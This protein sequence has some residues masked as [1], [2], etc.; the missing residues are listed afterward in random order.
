MPK[1]LNSKL[2]R[3]GEEIRQGRAKSA[4]EE[5]QKLCSRGVD[6]KYAAPIASLARRAA[7]ADLGLRALHKIVRPTGRLPIPA[8]DE[9]KLEYAACL[10]KIGAT[11]ESLDILESLDAAK[12]PDVLLFKTF[13]LVSQWEYAATIP[14]L[15][16]YLR[17]PDIT[18]YWRMVAKVN[19]A[20]AFVYER[21]SDEAD[22]CLAEI[23]A[24]TKGTE[25][26]LLHGNA[27]HLSLANAVLRRDFAK[28]AAC[29]KECRALLGNT[30]LETFFLRKWEAIAAMLQEGS[31]E[32]MDAVRAEATKRSHWETLRDCDRYSLL[33]TRDAA[34][35][36]KLIFG[37]PYAGFRKSLNLGDI[38]VPAS[39]VWGLG[40]TAHVVK[41]KEFEPGTALNRLLHALATDFY[42]PFR[43]AALYAR[44][45]PG[46]F[47][48]PVSA[49]GKMHQ[50]MKRF[51]DLCAK[52]K[53]KL[54]VSEAGGFY[55]LTAAEGW[56]VEVEL[57]A[58]PKER[59]ESGLDVLRGRCPEG[60][61]TAQS[62]CEWLGTPYRSTARL[63][64]K[65]VEQGIL[66]KLG[67]GAATRYRF[68][69]LSHAA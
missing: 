66:D 53:I 19:L 39:Y 34:T 7:V 37:T 51:R 8:S 31:T 59:G 56:G 29:V 13:N 28:A 42:R 50:L 24:E 15:E 20:S 48:N 63:L 49:P 18:H 44:V 35:Y 4:Q 38:P 25:F 2:E 26:I 64:A 61:F 14:L 62:A 5:L 17:H 32:V 1:D 10:T 16:E 23:L 12:L 3:I 58:K 11:E 46:E 36:L 9:E 22:R 54:E 21:R 67:K 43:L 65:G 33:V 45:Y 30:D 55:R 41:V 27:M 60:E 47:Y 40:G 6:R 52:K 69:R 68:K 57:G